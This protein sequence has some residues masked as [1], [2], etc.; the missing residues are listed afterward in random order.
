MLPN[1]TRPM[2]FSTFT[3]GLPQTTTLS[4]LLYVHGGVL[5]LNADNQY[6]ATRAF[7]DIRVGITLSAGCIASYPSITACECR[8]CSRQR[9]CALRTRGIYSL[10]AVAASLPRVLQRPSTTSSRC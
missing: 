8:G 10:V 4:S 2:Q 7:P 5:V 9:G 6:P 3:L 1:E